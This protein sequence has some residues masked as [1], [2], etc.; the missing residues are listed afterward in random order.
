MI[1]RS[2]DKCVVMVMAPG[3]LFGCCQV[4]VGKQEKSRILLQGSE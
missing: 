4:A 3:S 1:D 2:G